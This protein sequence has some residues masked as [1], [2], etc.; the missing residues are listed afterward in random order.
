[1]RLEDPAFDYD[2]RDHEYAAFRRPDARIGQPIID[3]LVGSNTVANIGAGTGSY[4]PDDRYV[5]AVEP[6]SSMRAQ[7]VAL[8]KIPAVNARADELP[9]DDRS[10]DAV[11]GVLTIHHWPDVEAGLREMKR[12]SARKIVL[13]TYDPEHLDRFWNADYFPEL[14]EIERRRYPSIESVQAAIGVEAKVSCV[15]I[16]IDCSDGFQEAFY[17]RPDAFLD[18]GVRRAQSAWGFLAEDVEATYVA[19]L[20]DELRSGAWDRKY[21]AH[22]QMPHFAG[23]LRLLEFEL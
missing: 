8:G 18:P 9:F 22:R 12:V 1:M 10:F 23:A 2:H 4:E 20:S 13:M 15:L 17:A 5:V 3:A 7:R 14:I 11:M 6:S 21:G 16:P 19:R